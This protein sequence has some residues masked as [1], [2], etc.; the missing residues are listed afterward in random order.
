M[1]LENAAIFTIFIGNHHE[2]AL[3]TDYE[4]SQPWKQGMFS[5]FLLDQLLP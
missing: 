4:V 1:L 2:A 3:I 5:C